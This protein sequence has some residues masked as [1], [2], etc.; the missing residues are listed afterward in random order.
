MFQDPCG[1]NASVE[2]CNREQGLPGGFVFSS[3][4]SAPETVVIGYR[5]GAFY[6]KTDTSKLYVFNG[7][8]RTKVGWVILN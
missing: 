5:L 3:G 4:T 8:P 6:L 7:T 1:V 2:A